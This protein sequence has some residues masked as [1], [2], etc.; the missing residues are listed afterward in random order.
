MS[1]LKSFL[2]EEDGQDMVEY[3]LIL[4]LVVAGAVGIYTT[5]GTAIT[6]GLSTVTTAIGNAL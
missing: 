1:F 2:V 3:G 5:F 4:A 6:T